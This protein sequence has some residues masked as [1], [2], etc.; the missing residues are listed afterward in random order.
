LRVGPVTEV[1][2][3]EAYLL[4]GNGARGSFATLYFDRESGLLVRTIRYTPSKVGNVPTQVDYEN[5]RDVAGIKFPHRWTVT[6]L[7]GRDIF[8][9]SEVRFN[10]P[11]D[12]AKFGEPV[13]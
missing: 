13:I 3:K 10:L 1:N 7:D 5:Y 11:I 2:G 9:F 4:Q 12:A 6:W 8:D